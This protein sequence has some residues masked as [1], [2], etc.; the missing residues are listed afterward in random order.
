MLLLVF[1][2]MCTHTWSWPHHGLML[3]YSLPVESAC[4]M[5]SMVAFVGAV[6]GDDLHY[7]LHLMQHV[8]LRDMA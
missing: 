2:T 1:L 6:P 7:R 8:N 4:R 3:V 5:R